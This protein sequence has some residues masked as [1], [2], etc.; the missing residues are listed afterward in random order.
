MSDITVIVEDVPIV[1][2]VVEAQVDVSVTQ[3]P[4]IIVEVASGSGGA[5]PG[6]TTGQLLQ[7]TSSADYA[8]GW[9]PDIRVSA[10]APTNPGVST[11]WIDIS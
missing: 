9:G 7:K 11:V 2:G 10:I 4:P 6:G 8:V 1:I 3:P 5:P